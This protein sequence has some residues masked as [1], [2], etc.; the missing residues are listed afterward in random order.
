MQKKEQNKT[1]C[2]RQQKQTKPLVRK[3][4]KKNGKQETQKSEEKKKTQ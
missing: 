2:K 1:F 4:Y 3:N